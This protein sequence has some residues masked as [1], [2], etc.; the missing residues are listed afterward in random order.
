VPTAA[1]IE[2]RDDDAFWAARRVMAFDDQMIRAIVKAGSYSDPAAEQYLADVLIKRRDKIGRAYLTRVSPIVHPT[3]SAEGVLAFANVAVK[4]GFAPAAA[5][6]RA[7]WYEFDNTTGKTTSLGET[8]GQQERLQAPERLPSRPGAFVK[9]EVTVENSGQPA[10]RSIQIYF[11]RQ[12]DGWKLVGLERMPDEDPRLP[13][14]SGSA[15]P[16]RSPAAAPR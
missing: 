16:P 8:R 7:V 11:R 10:S 12:A 15:S 14:T 6:Y 9:L 5:Q 2:M 3:L 13:V 4:A 1:Y